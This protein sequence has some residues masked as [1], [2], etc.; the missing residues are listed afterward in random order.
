[1]FFVY[2]LATVGLTTLLGL[3]A[4]VAGVLWDRPTQAPAD[5]YDEALAAVGRLQARAWEAAHELSEQS[6]PKD[7]A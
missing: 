1:V 6:R 4:W 3:A 2:F 5:P 7:S